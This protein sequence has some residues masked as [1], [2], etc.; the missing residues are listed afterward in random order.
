MLGG[1]GNS[2]ALCS[3]CPV[4]MCSH[5]AT[6]GTNLALCSKCPVWCLDELTLVL[7]EILL[8]F[9]Q[10]TLASANCHSIHGGLQMDWSYSFLRM[11][12]LPLAPTQKCPMQWWLHS[13]SAQ[14][15]SRIVLLPAS[16][17]TLFSTYRSSHH[18]KDDS[19]WWGNRIAV[20]PI[21]LMSK[22]CLSSKSY[23]MAAS[24]LL[25]RFIVAPVPIC[26]SSNCILV[27]A[28]NMN[29][30]INQGCIRA[31][32]FSQLIWPMR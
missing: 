17:N 27:F 4:W 8:L 9:A 14:H 11:I 16:C 29:C 1:R 12:H 30:K 25:L 28:T 22:V 7:E 3:K 2:L 23:F 15:C 10:N 32:L 18:C 20:K 26:S 6:G 19:W 13:I 5:G 21:S 24:F 31:S